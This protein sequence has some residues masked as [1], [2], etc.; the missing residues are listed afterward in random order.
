M[1]MADN[2]RPSYLSISSTI[3]PGRIFEF[4][5]LEILTAG[6][7]HVNL[8]NRC[9]PGSRISKL[10]FFVDSTSYSKKKTRI[11]FFSKTSPFWS[12]HFE[13]YYYFLAK[14]GSNIQNGPQKCQ[15]MRF[16]IQTRR[17]FK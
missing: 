9:H 2:R 4:Q 10:I 5:N 8:T 13:L 1:K 6:L 14:K 11:T 7:F 3:V 17:Y 12:D 16:C 15:D